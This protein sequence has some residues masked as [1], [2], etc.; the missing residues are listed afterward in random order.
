MFQ[1]R[2]LAYGDNAPG[3]NDLEFQRHWDIHTY[4]CVCVHFLPK[5]V[6]T[7]FLSIS[8]WK[9]PHL[10]GFDHFNSHSSGEDIS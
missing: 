3:Q 8:P 9:L 4:T 10:V 2:I 5:M 7:Q 6:E 1:T